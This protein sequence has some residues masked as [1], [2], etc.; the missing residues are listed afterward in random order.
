MGLAS[1]YHRFFPEK[2]FAHL[3][4]EE[5]RRIVEMSTSGQ[6]PFPTELQS[7]NTSD[8]ADRGG[9]IALQTLTTVRNGSIEKVS[10]DAARTEWLAPVKRALDRVLEKQDAASIY[11]VGCGHGINLVALRRAFGDKLEIAGSDFS[12]RRIEEGRRHFGNELEVASLVQQ[13]FN[14]PEF[15][16]G[17][18]GYD[19]VMSMGAISF[20][21]SPSTVIS[22][23]CKMAMSYVVLIEPLWE[24]AMPHQRAYLIRAG[25]STKIMQGAREAAFPILEAGACAISFSVKHAAGFVVLDVRR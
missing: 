11:E 4:R 14:A 15:G 22:R 20:A 5:G 1:A 16:S 19:V 17:N 6:A 23:M 12:A 9:Q 24:F 25:H 3:L 13:S 18:V 8:G 10:F 2:R 21:D 7:K